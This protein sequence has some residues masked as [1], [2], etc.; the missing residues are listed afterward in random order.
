MQ[1]TGEYSVPAPRSKVWDALNDPSILRVCIE[2]CEELAWSGP[3]TLSATIRASV[4]PISA[5]FAGKLW[6]SDVV[7]LCSYTLNGQG[8]GGAAGFVKGF[9]SV[10]LS[11][12]DDGG[13]C[14]RYR[15]ETN[16]G[17]ILADVGSKLVKGMADRTAHEFF[18]RFT[19]R[20]IVAM[21]AASKQEE[22]RLSGGEAEPVGDDILF[23]STGAARTLLADW[24]ALLDD[25]SVVAKAPS[26]SITSL[27]RPVVPLS[28]PRLLVIAGGFGLF[29]LIVLLLAVL[30]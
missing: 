30:R 18:D 10:E 9:A 19:R 16:I 8:E 7:P 26:G 17:G 24:D 23:A 28:D 13:C 1:F 20:L 3:E 25:G 22:D 29:A 21:A 5:R 4:G 27:P 15:C 12:Q 14:L 2:G 6:L 11:D